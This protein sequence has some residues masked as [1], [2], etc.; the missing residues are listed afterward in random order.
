MKKQVLSY[1]CFITLN[2]DKTIFFWF[3][4]LM[5]TAY[6]SNMSV[7]VFPINFPYS[8]W[9]T[10]PSKLKASPKSL[11]N[12]NLWRRNVQTQKEACTPL[13][14]EF[15]ITL[16][17]ISYL[18]FYECEKSKSSLIAKTWLWAARYTW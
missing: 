14:Q 2:L 15:L 18:I 3:V 10:L 12:K 16:T 17:I 13:V 7:S 9:A 5:A 1:F 6:S 8:E 4:P 11:S